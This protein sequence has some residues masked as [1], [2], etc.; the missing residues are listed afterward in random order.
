MEPLWET[1][2][3]IQQSQTEGRTI[4]LP[5]THTSVVSETII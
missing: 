3:P 4:L 1:K 5:V 2:G